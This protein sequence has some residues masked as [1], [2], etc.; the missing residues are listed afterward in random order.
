MIFN[1]YEKG[2]LVQN[3]KITRFERIK[4]YP[5]HMQN[6]K[7]KANIS[8]GLGCPKKTKKFKDENIPL[9]CE[10]MDQLEKKSLKDCIV[11]INIYPAC[12]GL[13]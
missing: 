8:A 9:S 13:K 1:K 5:K 11:F 4:L 3:L 7:C 2:S 12:C 6:E 10:Y